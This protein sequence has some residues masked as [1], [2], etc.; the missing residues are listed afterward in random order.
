[1]VEL[2]DF[3]I[4]E[5]V[6]SGSYST[7]YKA[8]LKVRFIFSLPT[9]SGRYRGKDNGD[10]PPLSPENLFKVV[11]QNARGKLNSMGGST[12]NILFAFTKNKEKNYSRNKNS[13][14]YFAL[15]I[16]GTAAQRQYHIS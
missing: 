9:A 8:Q 7:V 10:M 2:T 15:K 3:V 14:H 1:M 13:V 4:T 6:G 11:T 16:I 5:K 12:R